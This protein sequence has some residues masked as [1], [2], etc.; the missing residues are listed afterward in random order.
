MAVHDH[1]FRHLPG[2]FSTDE[3][4]HVWSDENRTAKYLD[5]EARAGQ[6]AGPSSGSSRPTPP[7]RSSATA[8]WTRSTCAKLRQQTERIG[9]PILG[10]VTQ[11]NAA[12]PRQARRVLHWGATT[13]DI[14]DTATVLQIREGLDLVDAELAAISAALAALAKKHRD[15]PMIG[16]S[17]LQQA[18]PIT[19]GYKMAGLLAGDRT[20]PRAADATA[21][22]GAGRRVR[23]RRG[24]PGL[25]R[26][27]GHGNAGRA[28]APSWAWPSR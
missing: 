21:R 24:H 23:R 15:T 22:A 3:M 20:A 19:F 7:R 12:L 14:T 18:I 27:R 16:R 26:D 11:I 6:G 9:Y 25:A 17:N 13:Q 5:I 8:S 1:R 10:V 28:D 4:R 2:I